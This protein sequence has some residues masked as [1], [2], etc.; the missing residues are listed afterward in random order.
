MPEVIL[1]DYNPDND[2]TQLSEVLKE[3]DLFDS[4]YETPEKLARWVEIQP[5][6]IIVP[7]V[8]G[9]IVGS[10]YLQDGIIPHIFRLAVR[11]DYRKQ[12][13]GT[14]LLYE[15]ERRAQVLGHDFVE[16]FI[17]PGHPELIEWYG[18]RG[19]E[20]REQYTDMFKNLKQAS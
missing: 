14:E 9:E 2:F 8:K 4:D 7:E 18:K 13:I 15:A 10:I 6:S 17:A 3:A 5:G 19:Y 16:L 1:R 20:G 11:E 12:G